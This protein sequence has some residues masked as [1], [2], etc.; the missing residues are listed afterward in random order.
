MVF[1]SSVTSTRGGRPRSA[2]HRGYTTAVDGTFS[3]APPYCTPGGELFRLGGEAY[4]PEYQHHS[5]WHTGAGLA[6]NNKEESLACFSCPAAGGWQVMT[7]RKSSRTPQSARP[8]SEGPRLGLRPACHSR[9]APRRTPG[10]QAQ[11]SSRSSRP[12][13][14][15]AAPPTRFTGPSI[16]FLI[17]YAELSNGLLSSAA[18]PK[19]ANY[20]GSG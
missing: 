6:D 8:G 2:A 15:R 14:R 19:M 9:V 1:R 20:D 10:R 7:P 3:K 16:C 12:T 5:N 4:N 17:K 13:P 18:E 11:V